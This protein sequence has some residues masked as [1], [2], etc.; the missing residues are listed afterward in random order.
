MKFQ[1]QPIAAAALAT[2]MAVL[3]APL[4]QA[5]S[6]PAPAPVRPAA[7]A[8]A[9]QSIEITGIRASILKSIATKRSA[10]TNVD[11]VSAEDVGKMPDKNI[12]DALSR[13][14]GV[15][16]QYG[17]ALA[18]DEA[19]RVSI[20]GTSPNLNLV[21]ING[22]A[23]S[24][25]DWHVG[26][27][28]G[29][30]RSV[31]FGLMPSQLIGQSIVYK[32]SRADITEG[33]ISGSVDIIP[34]KPLSFK[35]GV[36][37]EVSLGLVHATLAKKTDPQISG[38][39]NWRNDEGTLGFMAQLFKEDRHLRR[40]GQE[41]F[42]YNVVTAAQAAASGNAD[43]AGKR[44]TGSLNSAMFEGVRKRSGGYFG[45]Q[46]RPSKDIE[47]N[48]SAFY[49]ELNADNYNSSGYA[50]PFGLVNGAGYLIQNARITGDVITSANIVR[51]TGSTANVVGFQFDHFNR[52]GAQST[53]SFYDLD[54]KWNV[55]D[56]LSVKGRVGYTEGSGKTASQPSL[57]YGLLNPQS[58]V[59]SQTSDA[60]A[61]YS[62]NN[63]AGGA[64]DLTRVS[65]FAMLTNQGAAV[66]ALDKETYVH[67][68]ADYRVD[69]GIL[70]NLKFG[71]RLAT[72]DRTYAVVNPR[73][74]A[75]DDANGPIA[76]SSPNFPF[77]PITG[78]SLIKTT[79]LP[80]SLRPTPATLY[81]TN[82]F[83]GG[84][85][86]FPRNL[87][88]FDQGQMKAFT[89]QYI[90]WDPV[91]NRNLS[92]GFEV[93]EENN[94]AYVMGEFEVDASLGGNVGVRLVQTKLRSVSYQALVNGTAAGQCVPLQPCSVPGAIVGSRVATFV[95]RVVETS[96]D[97]V[98]PSLNLRWDVQRDVVA[99]LGLSRSLGRANYNELAGAVT[100][101]D[102]LL[103]GSSGNPL[104]KPIRS[105]NLDVSLAWY[106]APRAYVSGGLFTQKISDYVKTG[107]S[108]IDYFNISQNRITSYAVT[109]RIGVAAKLSGAEAALEMPIVGGFGLGLNGTYVKSEDADGVPLLGTS[110]FTYN[111][112]GF[113]EDDKFSA[114][115]AW[116]YRTDYAIGFVG[117]GSRKPIVNSAGVITQYNGQQRYAS[118]GALSLSIGYKF[119]KDLSI[120]LDG[121][122]LNDPIRRTYYINENAPG[123]WHQNG[124]QFFLALR[125]K[126]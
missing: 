65:N 14:P 124:R 99:R 34:R 25:G 37:G 30:G 59:L 76:A 104:L 98:L 15:N 26:D 28:A 89:D 22:H 66:K 80:D 36:S 121:N 53:S 71:G 117:D 70:N 32:S 64:I 39:I 91:L 105:N 47:L 81:P 23:L 16:V 40:D 38:L 18:M 42:G 96:N 123:Y 107:V 94:A 49:T 33:G 92:G 85:G 73:W 87:F 114:S 43:L 120:H 35:K 46:F 50:L 100:L 27:Q 77:T 108:A 125:A 74:N 112:R 41:I 12:A 126:M 101:N 103:T 52:Q 68:D 13:L 5:Q 9:T 2:V 86:N 62:I 21:T 82:W 29:S 3:V 79:V 116:N 24:A 84:E 115:L 31:G 90:N 45:A 102:T 109:S 7:G 67:L 63:A 51:P 106:F 4:A 118:E 55:N 60:P 19:E 78:G 83:A 44:L 61:Q 56:K 8:E 20:R 93:K 110:K 6:T 54:G 95:Q 72:H 122:N 11:V 1:R 75:Q 97:D 111:L 119:N 57:V 69:L 88:R 10:D 113:Y 17:G 58:I 48:A